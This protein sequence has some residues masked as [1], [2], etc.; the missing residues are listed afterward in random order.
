MAEGITRPWDQRK[1][2]GEGKEAYRAFGIY[3]LDRHDRSLAN[4]ANQLGVSKSV[5]GGWSTRFAWGDRCA[6]FDSHITNAQVESYARD[7]AEVRSYHMEITQNLLE[8]LARNMALWKAGQDPSIRWTQAFGMALKS[9]QTALQLRE[10]TGR[11]EGLLEALIQ[12]LDR[13]LEG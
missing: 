3:M 11:S 5:V 9:Q 6:A 12:K 4:T 8:H 1:S 10:E 2:D 13:G 7:V